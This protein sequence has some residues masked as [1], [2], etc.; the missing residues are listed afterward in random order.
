[1]TPKNQ[2]GRLFGAVY[3]T[4][5]DITTKLGRTTIM[6]N[7]SN[8]P[9]GFSGGNFVLDWLAVSPVLLDVFTCQWCLAAV[10]WD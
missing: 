1:M 9:A 4:L 3:K 10:D 7:R 5:V 6:I 2:S 8:R